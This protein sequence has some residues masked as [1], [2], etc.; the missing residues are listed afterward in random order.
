VV[1]SLFVDFDFDV[2]NSI[3]LCFKCSIFNKSDEIGEVLLFLFLLFYN[4]FFSIKVSNYISE[5]TKDRLKY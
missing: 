4:L 1:F 3:N 2:V 5:F